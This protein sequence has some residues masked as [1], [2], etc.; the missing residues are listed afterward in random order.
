MVVRHAKYLRFTSAT[1]LLIGLCAPVYRS[2]V[3]APFDSRDVLFGYTLFYE[4]SRLACLCLLATAVIAVVGARGTMYRVLFVMSVASFAASAYVGVR[5]W[6][7]WQHWRTVDPEMAGMSV[8]W[9]WIPIAIGVLLA[10]YVGSR[11]IRR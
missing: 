4:E 5:V 10:L 3:I 9:A 7:Q 2:P 6:R 1:A 11:G 8:G